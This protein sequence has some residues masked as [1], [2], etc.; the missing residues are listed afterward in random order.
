MLHLAN[1][2]FLLLLVLIPIMALWWRWLRRRGARHVSVS[3]AEIYPDAASIWKVRAIASLPWLQLAA[4]VLLI[5]ALARPQILNTFQV[6]KH[7]GIDIL[8]ALDI[9]GSMASV[10]FKP[11]NR[12]EV[13][14]TVIADFIH[15]R[16][17]DRIGL[18]VFAGTSFTRCPLTIDDSMLLNALD[19]TRIGDLEDGTAL[20]MALA[21]SVN[22][23]RHAPTATRII[24]LITDGVNNRGEIAPRDAAS[25]AREF[26]IKVYT[27]GVGRRGQAPYPVTD[28][29]GQKRF[30]MVNVEIDEDLLK[31][32]ASTTG[33]LYFRATD[34]DSLERIF[35][36]IDR[37][38][39]S[40]VSSRRVVQ[41]RELFSWFMGAGLLLLV[42][43]AVAQRTW[44]HELP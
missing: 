33:G 35:S 31:E 18:V 38:E 30:A 14:K 27:I 21:T 40:E 37:W 5:A 23:I 4:L 26:G 11:R 34:K 10:D 29:L 8:V 41:A 13:A 28:A 32:I 2:A 16:R 25:I 22:R 43:S 17:S 7:R 15:R 6:E 1:K 12:L 42:I 3:S 39:K 19:D 44:L 36:E 24:I 9:S 20:G